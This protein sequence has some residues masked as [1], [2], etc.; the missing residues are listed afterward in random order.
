MQI[1]LGE[2]SQT[3]SGPE[4]GVYVVYVNGKWWRWPYVTAPLCRMAMGGL[5]AGEADA[6]NTKDAKLA[7][8]LADNSPS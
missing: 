7:G 2:S 1:G 4:K 6:K 3:P 5:I 8:I